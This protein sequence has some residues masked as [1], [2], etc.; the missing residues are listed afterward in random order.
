MGLRLEISALE[1]NILCAEIHGW[2]ALG[3]SCVLRKILSTVQ[4]QIC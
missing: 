2:E 4:V 1:E 3:S